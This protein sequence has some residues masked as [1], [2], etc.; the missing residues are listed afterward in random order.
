MAN[1]TVPG[2]TAIY[3][4]VIEV[5]GVPSG[6]TVGGQTPE[7]VSIYTVIPTGVHISMTDGEGTNDLTA[8]VD[9]EA[10]ARGM[11]HVGIYN[12]ASGSWVPVNSST[13]AGN[14]GVGA[15]TTHAHSFF[16][17]TEAALA[18]GMASFALPDGYDITAE[19]ATLHV[20]G[21][22]GSQLHIVVFDDVFLKQAGA[23]F[24][25]V[26]SDEGVMEGFLPGETN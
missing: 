5:D 24:D 13:T 26:V 18:S 20:T 2:F 7:G 6:V 4:G 15:Y 23:T 11:V 10:N 14:L 12:S 19:G 22:E 3:G 25:G 17:M 8:V 1:R 21:P 9:H 16:S